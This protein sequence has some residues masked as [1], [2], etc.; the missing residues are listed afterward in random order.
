MYGTATARSGLCVSMDQ[1][2]II[3]SKI[4]EH[5]IT[6]AL[7]ILSAIVVYFAAMIGIDSLS[8]DDVVVESKT[9]YSCISRAH[10]QFDKF[11]I[12]FEAGKYST[13]YII[14]INDQY[15]QQKR[16]CYTDHHTYFVLY[17]D[18]MTDRETIETIMELR[19]LESKTRPESL[20]LFEQMS[21]A[22]Q[23]KFYDSVYNS[24][25]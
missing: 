8:N 19:S 13:E 3:I 7:C 12:N 22:E 10:E 25:E 2:K 16:Y 9:F 17:G 11:W 24:Q 15:Q 23:L 4:W 21:V 20:I 14:E 1:V 18:S 6:E 5:R